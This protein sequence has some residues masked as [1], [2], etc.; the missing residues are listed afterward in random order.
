M[1]SLRLALALAT[2]SL[3]A[4]RVL[5]M[6]CN[7]LPDDVAIPRAGSRVPRNVRPKLLRQVSLDVPRYQLVCSVESGPSGEVALEQR[8]LGEGPALV[9]EL[10]PL[11]ALVAGESC[12]V[13]GP[14]KSVRTWFVVDERQDTTA[15][16]LA[17][18]GRA[19]VRGSSWDGARARAEIALHGLGDDGAGPASLLL[20]LWVGS[21]GEALD[22][23]R[24]PTSWARVNTRLRS[25]PVAFLNEGGDCEL[26]SLEFPEHGERS[27][28]GI[29]AV[30]LAG[31]ASPPVE[32]LLDGYPDHWLARQLKKTRAPAWFEPELRQGATTRPTQLPVWWGALALAALAA[33]AAC[34]IER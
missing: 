14:G 20:A 26:P 25:R 21:P 13:V 12:A 3:W 2:L 22:Y 27:R 31:N 29:R 32:G 4:P 28:L 9:V 19:Q 18:L 5:A 17:G 1:R 33:A 30:D 10:T 8:Q 15:P 34:W 7:P 11:R 16:R 24:P 6:D 23:G